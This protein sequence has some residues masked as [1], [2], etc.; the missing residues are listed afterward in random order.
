VLVLNDAYYTGWSAAVD[1]QPVPL[2]PANVAVRGV[3]LPAG[4]HRVTFTYRTP[5]LRL[6]ALISLVTLGVLGLAVFAERA[7]RNSKP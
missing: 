2:L 5:G 1:G 4:N 7:R 3:R 6:G